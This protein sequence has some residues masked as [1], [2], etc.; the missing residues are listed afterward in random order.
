MSTFKLNTVLWPE[1]KKKAFTLSYDDGTLQDGRFIEMLDRYGIKATFNLNPGV[2]GEPE[3]LVV[4]E[5]GLDVNYSKYAASQIKEVYK[6]HE[7]AGH[8]MTHRG[9]KNLPKATVAYEVVQCKTALEKILHKLVKGMAYPY[10][11]YDVKVIEI[12][13]N[14]GI[15]YSRTVTST[16][17]FDITDNFLAWNPTCYHVEKEMEELGEQFINLDNSH[18]YDESKLYYLW[19]HAYELDAYQMWDRLDAFLQKMSGHEEIWYATNGEIYEYLQA[20]KQLQ[21]SSDGSLV[22]NPTDKDVWM[23]IDEEVYHIKSGT[24]VEVL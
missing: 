11:M 3:H 16:H 13:R 19:G 6:N 18:P 1:G 7:V 10:G 23:L 5:L 8:G 22:Y 4:P 9:M 2:F 14:C 24:V 17:G 12:L 20:A 15:G 21:Y